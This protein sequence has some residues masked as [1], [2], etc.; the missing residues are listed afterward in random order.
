M[1]QPCGFEA[2][3]F[4]LIHAIKRGLKIEKWLFQDFKSG[5]SDRQNG[6][7]KKEEKET[8]NRKVVSTEKVFCI[9]SCLYI[10]ITDYLP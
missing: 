4:F 2:R 9:F 6:R 8:E 7:P 1:A 3:K 10:S 5:V